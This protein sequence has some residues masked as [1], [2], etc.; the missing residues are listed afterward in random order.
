M[1]TLQE[2]YSCRAIVDAT[3]Q[4]VCHIDKNGHPEHGCI[5]SRGRTAAELLAIAQ[6]I[7]A[8]PELLAALHNLVREND[9]FGGCPQSSPAW[10]VARAA[11]AKA[12]GQSL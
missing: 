5:T 2:R 12:R 10:A 6:L 7:A 4:D 3:G 1:Y 8:A 9:E 11:L